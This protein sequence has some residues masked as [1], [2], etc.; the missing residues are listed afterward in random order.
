MVGALS[1]SCGY[2]LLIAVITAVISWMIAITKGGNHFNHFFF[3]FNFSPPFYGFIITR[4]RVICK[5]FLKFFTQKK[6][7]TKLYPGKVFYIITVNP[8]VRPRMVGRCLDHLSVIDELLLRLSRPLPVF[9]I[10]C[11][12]SVIS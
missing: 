6:D 3:I 10:G 8:Y 7:L 2:S 4:Y 12:A 5:C 1:G 9:G 11:V